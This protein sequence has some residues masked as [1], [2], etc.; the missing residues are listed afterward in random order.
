MIYYSIP[1]NSDK[2]LGR[3][4]NDFMH[5]LPRNDDYACFVD[6]D[7]IFTTPN[8]GVIIENIV[9][10]NKDVG[11]FTAITNRVACKWQIAPGVDINNN[12]MAYHRKFGQN[13]QEV[14]GTYCED[15]TNKGANDPM[16]GF[17]I[18]IKKSVWLK[19]GKF[20]EK[21]MLGIDNDIHEKILK[22]NEKMYM[23]KGV[24]LYHWYRWPDIKNITHLI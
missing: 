5:I 1:F 11:C 15:V 13:I 16:S 17:L 9:N 18:L 12:D 19:C 8:Y 4:Y 23:M 22:K 2:N 6:G 3:S 20:L 7:T 21:K 10:E 14:Y 24:Y